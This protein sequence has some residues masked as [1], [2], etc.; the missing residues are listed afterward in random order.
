MRRTSP[1]LVTLP[2]TLSATL[3]M[4][5]LLALGCSKSDPATPPANSTTPPPAGTATS[6][7][8]NV[9]E[10]AFSPMYS[11]YDGVHTF[12]IPAIVDGIAP[13]AIKWSA[14]DPSMVDLQSDPSTGGVLITT[15]KAGTVD[16]IASAGS[17]CGL[18]KLTIAQADPAAWELGSE[19][20]TKGTTL[21]RG[22]G[23]GLGGPQG[24]ADA[25]REDAAC[26]NCH[27]PTANG[28][29]RTVAHTP[30]QIGGFTDAELID[31]F[32]KGVVPMGGYFDE[33]IVPYQQWQSFHKWEMTAEAQKG[34]VVYLRSITPAAQTGA[35]NFGGR[36]DGGMGPRGDGGR[37]EGG[38]PEVGGGDPADA[39]AVD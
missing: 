10:V 31:I 20:Y 3:A 23:G 7:A 30:T 32:T 27:G 1:A 19:R 18:S 24:G 28:P 11:A 17:L 14:S 26:T 12:Q 25:G 5:A 8:E 36:G 38:R 22:P 37:R 9:L 21:G 2:A 13:A 34:M 6:C 33:T 16:I 4:S 35:R 29:F 15:R 39:G